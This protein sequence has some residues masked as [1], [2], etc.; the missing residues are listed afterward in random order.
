MNIH[1]LTPA[2][3]ISAQLNTDSIETIKSLGIQSVI[4][5]RPDGE[6]PN[7]PNFAQIQ[8][9]LAVAGITH[10]YYHPITMPTADIAAAN[11]FIQ[12]LNKLPSPTLAYCRSGTR[13]TLLWA[14]NQAAQGTPLTE[15]ITKADTIGIDLRPAE[16]KL[17]Q[18][19]QMNNS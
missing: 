12:Q 10:T 2:L 7:Q 4:C 15:I 19:A 3:Y 18:A 6:E 13:S 5:N 11:E 8:A 14:I 16:A 17:Q 9:E 1:R